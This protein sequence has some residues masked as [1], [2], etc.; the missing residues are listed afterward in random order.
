MKKI[1]ILWGLWPNTT[2]EFYLTINAKLSEI[3][4]PEIVIWNAP[5]DRHKEEKYIKGLWCHE[6]YNDILSLGVKILNDAQVD[7]ICIPCNTVHEFHKKLQMVS[8]VPILHIVEEVV[9]YLNQRNMT[10]V[11]LLWTSQLIQQK[12]Y[13]QFWETYS[14]EFVVPN[15]DEQKII[16]TTIIEILNFPD[17]KKEFEKKIFQV[18]QSYWEIPIVLGCT[19]LQGM[20]TNK[21]CFDSIEILQESVIRKA[22]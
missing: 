3:K 22:H 13:Q 2:A 20:F 14:I 5:L 17:R 8:R 16:D 18:I 9:R 21:I 19:D 15:Q 6:Y 4:R 1:W 12:L 11:L 7:F 10:R